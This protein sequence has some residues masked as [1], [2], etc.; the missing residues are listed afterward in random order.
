MITAIAKELGLKPGQVETVTQL[1]DEGATIPFIARYRKERTGS[2]DEV[3]IAAIRDRL[4]KAKELAARKQAIITSLEERDLITDD[5]RKAVDRAPTRTD[6][7][8]LYEKYRPKRK[9]KA[10]AARELGLDPLATLLLK[11]TG[12]DPMAEA[13]RFVN[14]DK[15]VETPEQALAGA[16][17]ILAETVNEDAPI[18]SAM[19]RLFTSKAQIKSTVKKNKESDGAKFRDYF[20]WSEPAAKTPSHRIL[21]MFRGEAESFLTVHV[22][23]PEETALSVVE[24]RVIKNSTKAAREVKTAVK[25]AYK[26]LMGKSLEK[27]TMAALKLSAD[28]ESIK[29][30]ASNIKELLLFP[31]LGQKRVLAIDPGF[32]T[33]CKVVCLD[34]QGALLHHDVIYPFSNGDKTAAALKKLTK[35]YGT[36]AIAIGNGTAG[37]ETEAFVRAANLDDSIQ[38]IMVDES[39][40]SIYSASETARNEFPDHDITV[41]GA[42]SIGR[43]LMDPLAELVKIDPKSIGVGQYQHDVDQK[44]LQNALGDVIETCVNRVGVEVNTASAELL[45]HVAGLNK[46]IA[47]NIVKY[48]EA[49]GPFNQRR[50]L[51]KVPR[52]GPKAYEQCAGFLR[53]HDGANPLDRSGIHPESYK[54]VET[55]AK[56]AGH[57]VKELVGN[58]ALVKTIDLAPYVT[59][60][61]GMVT[62]K[63]IAAE[64][65]RPGRDPRESF[66]AFKFDD[67]IHKIEDLVPGMRVPGLVTNV[68][69][70]GAFVDIGVH[71][72]GLV[73]ISQLADRYVK[74]PNEVV[75]VRQQ[76]EVTILDVD[77]KRK[78]ISLSMRKS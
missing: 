44:L 76:V 64:L 32:R 41:R 47:A 56:N 13:R 39:G 3:A 25:D 14:P 72:D 36:E 49:N 34:R 22:L 70:F 15:G 57:T 4:A 63:D 9:T 27:E 12:S 45:T 33:G 54:T 20:D 40:A 51:L 19:R 69:A 46:T 62:L 67:T 61:T 48:R 60:T 18:R 78:R 37:R 59:E 24:N 42:V 17:D 58:E 10:Q 7:E 77:I 52:L 6:L 55:M 53:I 50:E 5:L 31:P 23:P 8:D 1:F 68:T 26:R 29:V 11:Q 16:R 30:F 21:A 71:Q 35:K 73:H 38:V 2:L 65:A 28:Q 43:R 75:K 74:D 66:K